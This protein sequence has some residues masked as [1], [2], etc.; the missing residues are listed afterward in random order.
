MAQMNMMG[1][2][3]PQGQPNGMQRP[4]Q[5][6]VNQQ[7]HPQILAT[8]QNE[9]PKFAGQWQSTFN[10]GLRANRIMQ[11]S[12]NICACEHFC[13]YT[14]ATSLDSPNSVSSS[15]TSASASVQPYSSRTRPSL[16]RQARINTTRT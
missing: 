9:L 8:L 16:A 12:V 15:Q 5:G 3:M 1:N 6:N 13:L 11:L 4:Q 14:N 10:L 7:P 2:G